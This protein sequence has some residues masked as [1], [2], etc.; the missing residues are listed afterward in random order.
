MALKHVQY[1]FEHFVTSLVVI[2]ASSHK[3]RK[4]KRA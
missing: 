3:K 1:F 2:R 4:S